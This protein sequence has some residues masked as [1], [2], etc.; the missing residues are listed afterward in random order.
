[1]A[2]NDVQKTQ[3]LNLKAA[4]PGPGCRECPERMQSS[5]VETPKERTHTEYTQGN[6]DKQT[7]KVKKESEEE[8]LRG[9]SDDRNE[10]YGDE[11]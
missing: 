2:Q 3:K 9:E 1:M 8:R 6:R 11:G 7:D 4:R 5:S 10:G